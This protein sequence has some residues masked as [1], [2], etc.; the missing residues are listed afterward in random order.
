MDGNNGRCLADGKKR[1]QRSGKVENVKKKI[2]ARAR[3]MLQ[4]GII[5]FGPVA[6]DKDRLE[7]AA[8]NSAGEKGEQKDKLDSLGNMA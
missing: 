1:M 3:K 6:G 4:H 2:H 8:R 7:A 5:N